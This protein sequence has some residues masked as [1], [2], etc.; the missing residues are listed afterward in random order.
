MKDSRFDPVTIDEVPQLSVNVSLL[1]N[2]TEQKDVNDW[3]I[4]KHGIIIKSTLKGR[5]YS[6]TFL[7]E[8][9]KEQNWSKT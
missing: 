9:A 1:I 2:F 3:E 5:S 8:V 6:G 4:G 7:P